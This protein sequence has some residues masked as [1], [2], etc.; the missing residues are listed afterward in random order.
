MGLVESGRSHTG[1]VTGLRHSG[2]LGP[3]MVDQPAR[4]RTAIAA[5]SANPTSSFLRTK[6]FCINGLV[7]LLVTICGLHPYVP[8]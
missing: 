7:L 3:F 8:G 6:L 4:S 1:V 2:V 5:T